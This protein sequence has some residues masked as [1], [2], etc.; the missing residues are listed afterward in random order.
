MSNLKTPQHIAI[1]MDGNGRWAKAHGLT[2]AE[3]HKKGVDSVHEVI[4]A[5]LENHVPYLTLWAFSTEN[6]KRSIEEVSTLIGLLRW[7]LNTQI[8]KLHKEGVRLR[9]IG[10]RDRF[11]SD[12]VDLIERAETLTE[13]NTK[14]NLTIALSY[15]G[16]DDILRAT[17]KIAADVLEGTLQLDDIDEQTMSDHLYTATLPD[18]DIILR[19][20]G[21]QRVSNFLLWQMAYS[22]F[23]FFDIMWPDFTK[24]TFKEALDAYEKRERRYGNVS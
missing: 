3:G 19:P 17:K 5:A 11:D 20:S 24:D 22:E 15:G 6:W 23:I 12:I 9:V 8:Q 1:I 7:Y 21:E 4:E 2:R 16:R 13:K 18:P 10:Q 14:L